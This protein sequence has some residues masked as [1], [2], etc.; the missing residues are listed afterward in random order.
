LS[1]EQ[2]E[3]EREKKKRRNTGCNIHLYVCQTRKL[4]YKKG[5]LVL[6]FVVVVA[7]N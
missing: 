6:L 5:L 7:H 1:N 3:E 4:V 2:E